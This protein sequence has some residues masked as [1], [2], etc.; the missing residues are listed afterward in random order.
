MR[1]CVLLILVLALFS[2]I[3]F[4]GCRSVDPKEQ[5]FGYGIV[6]MQKGDFDRSRTEFYRVLEIEPNCP[7]AEYNL[8]LIADSL[9]DIKNAI[10]W[11][12]LAIKHYGE[13]KTAAESGKISFT[14]EDQEKVSMAHVLL[15]TNYVSL[16]KIDVAIDHF[17]IAT[18]FTE[19]DPIIWE[20]LGTAYL[21]QEKIDLA[22]V[23]FKKALEVEPKHARAHI[24]LAFIYEEIGEIELAKYHHSHARQL[25]EDSPYLIEI[26]SWWDDW[27]KFKTR[28]DPKI[29]FIHPPK[30][31]ASE[32]K[33]RVGRAL[34]VFDN[35]KAI[36]YGRDAGTLQIIGP[37]KNYTILR[38][39]QENPYDYAV[40]GLLNFL[41][42][43]TEFPHYFSEDI[44][45]QEKALKS[46]KKVAD[47]KPK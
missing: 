42:T 27:K 28:L 14:E 6:Y 45:K 35:T 2:S 36:C 38:R 12:E 29:Q 40:S 17:K 44:E 11:A 31:V 23:S 37:D 43:K 26:L 7:E 20:N 4:T 13:R 34:V 24:S 32:K 16:K 47:K 5:Y 21:S 19:G 8:A 41:K 30:W 25:G 18:E 10:K 3:I 39:G 1:N 22:I 33:S 9:K 46:P 15:G